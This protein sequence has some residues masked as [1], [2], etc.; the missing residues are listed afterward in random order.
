MPIARTPLA[1]H[2]LKLLTRRCDD[3]LPVTMTPGFREFMY[4]FAK[5]RTPRPA[6][7]H[8]LPLSPS[9]L[10]PRFLTNPPQV[11]K[12]RL[13]AY[14]ACPTHAR[15]RSIAPTRHRLTFC[16]TFAFPFF[17]PL[18]VKLS[19]YRNDLECKHRHSY[20]K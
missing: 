20:L 12:I 13:F 14:I 6:L 9:V 19:N 11:S 1:R 5:T 16:L 8:Q 17:Y 2:H 10:S 7:R 18:P 15:Y 4:A 3:T